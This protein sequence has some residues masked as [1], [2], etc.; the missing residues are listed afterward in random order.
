MRS[1]VLPL[2]LSL[3]CAAV[4]V[5][6]APFNALEEPADPPAT[7][8]IGVLGEVTA[9]SVLPLVL[10]L[11]FAPA[12]YTLL[13]NSP[14]GSVYAGLHLMDAMHA[15]RAAGTR[16]T[17]IVSGGA[18]SMAAIILQ[19]CTERLLERTSALMFHTVS[20]TKAEGNAWD[21]ARLVREMR[22]LNK[23]LAIIAVSRSRMRLTEYVARTADEDYWVG[24][25]EA[26]EFGF[27]D[28]V[29]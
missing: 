4:P 22:A 9:D 12:S 25:E 24:W 20:V 13:I 5:A 28:G 27:I 8:G 15:A 26:L 6:P 3:A 7:T 16:V 17:C 2:V 23:R 14:G 29:L 1:L 19:A 11:A 21:L 10:D 18:Y